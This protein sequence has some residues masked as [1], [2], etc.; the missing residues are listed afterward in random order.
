MLSEIS[1]TEKYKYYMIS[2]ICGI[3]ENYK[4]QNECNKKK[5]TY[6]YIRDKTLFTS[7]DVIGRVKK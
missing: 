1:E 4:K 5:Q 3:E 2:L 6:R 7:E